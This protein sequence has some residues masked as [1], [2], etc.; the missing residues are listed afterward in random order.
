MKGAF[1]VK[2]MDREIFSKVGFLV[3]LVKIGRRSLSG[4]SCDLV[5]VQS[6]VYIRIHCM[7]S[8][9]VSLRCSRCVVACSKMRADTCYV[10]F[11][12]L[13]LTAKGHL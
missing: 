2:S 10:V 13:S 8:S 5:L 1:E 11:L 7:L 3:I 6:V 4:S 12:P 9:D